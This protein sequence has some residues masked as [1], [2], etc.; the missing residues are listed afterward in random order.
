VLAAKGDPAQA[1][2]RQRDVWFAE[3]GFISTS[4]YWRD[5]LEPGAELT[6]PAVIE[7]MD[8][9]TVVPPG[10]QAAI[11]ELGYIRLTPHVIARAAKQ[12]R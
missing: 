6:G 2:T 1:R 7:A 10:W 4:V 11:D 12:S 5:G 3:S 8:S 9:T